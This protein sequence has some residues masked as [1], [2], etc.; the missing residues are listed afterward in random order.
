[1]NNPTVE[2]QFAVEIVD[3][4]YREVKRQRDVLAQQV[5]ELRAFAREVPSM[6]TRAR[7][8][9]KLGEETKFDYKRH[10]RLCAY[11]I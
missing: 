5:E 7:I 10:A 8:D 2:Q 11:R 9:A 1:M 3:A 4:T 6:I